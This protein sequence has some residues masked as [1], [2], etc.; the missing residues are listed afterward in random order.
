MHTT[1]HMTPKGVRSVAI[2]RFALC[3]VLLGAHF[4]RHGCRRAHPH[5]RAIAQSAWRNLHDLPIDTSQ[6]IGG[7]VTVESR[8]IG[9]GHQIV[10]Q[11]DVPVT[12]GVPTAVDEAGAPVVISSAVPGSNNEVVVTLTGVPDNKRVKVTLPNVNGVDFSVS[13]G[14]LIGD[15]N[16]SRSVATSDIAQMK[17]HAGQGVDASNL[18]FDLNATGVITA[19]DISAVKSR[20]PRTLPEAIVPTGMMLNVSKT[21]PGAGSVSSASPGIDCG[22]DCSESY[23]SGTVVTLTATAATGSAFTMWGGACVGTTTHTCNTTMNAAKSAVANFMGAEAF[24]VDA[25][26]L[27]VTAVPDTARTVTQTIPVTGGT[28]TVTGADGTVYTLVVPADALL[29]PTAISMTPA[30]SLDSPDLPKD[31]AYGVELGPAGATFHNFVTLTITPPAGASVPIARQLPIGWSGTQSVVSLAAID[32]TSAVVKLKL[33]HFSGYALLLATTGMNA[34]LAPVRHRL[35]GDAEERLGSLAGERLS[36]ERQKQLLGADSDGILVLDDLFK[37]FDEQVVQPRI[38]AAGTSCAAGRLALQT[39]LGFER[40]KQLLGFAEGNFGDTILPVM[41]AATGA[42]TREEYA[43]CR[44]NHIITRILPYYLGVRRQAELLGVVVE[45]GPVWLQDAEAAVG[46]CLN[47][48]LQ[49]NSRLDYSD[50]VDVTAHTIVETVESRVKLPFNIGAALFGPGYI[51]SSQA[52]PDPLISRA[53]DVNYP[54]S[55]AQVSGVQRIGAGMLGALGFEP[56]EGSVAQR[57]TVKD[58]FF[59]PAVV[60]NGAGSGYTLTTFFAGSSGCEAPSSTSQENENWVNNGFGTWANAFIDPVYAMAIRN[61]TIVAGDIFATKDFTNQ[62]SSG[63][64]NAVV[65][66]GLVLFHKPAP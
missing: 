26:P 63:S 4:C 20:S 54:H 32:P 2:R 11:F 10:F 39:V 40:Q 65:T 9:A 53:Y 18:R 66:T 14:F 51:A 31:A 41:A 42:C 24:Q 19:A 64:D 35:G 28:I 7:A 33:L 17:A 46:K 61:W 21:G 58:F 57:A 55:C 62:E 47:F 37:L 50:G 52:G 45:P 56:N 6:N 12:F 29:E 15:V 59:T 22:A 49:V 43:L 16:N 8:A 36:Q 48:E 60:P 23:T 1:I 27:R 34:T 13:L 25:N 3:G 5:G 38:A 30:A 44:D